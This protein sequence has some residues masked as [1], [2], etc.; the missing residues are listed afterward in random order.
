LISGRAR[1]ARRTQVRELE[2]PHPEVEA[3]QKSMVVIRRPDGDTFF[4]NGQDLKKRMEFGMIG[5]DLC[6]TAVEIE[7]MRRGE[8]CEACQGGSFFGVETCL[9]PSPVTG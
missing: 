5:L 9:T 3:E 6:L 4:R 1:R 8:G 2:E 7:A